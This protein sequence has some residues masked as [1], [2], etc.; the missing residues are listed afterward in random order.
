MRYLIAGSRPVLSPKRSGTK[1][2]VSRP[3]MLSKTLIFV[4]FDSKDI[5][6]ESEALYSARIR[7]AFSESPV[8]IDV[9]NQARVHCWYKTRFGYSINPYTSAANAIATFPTTS[10]AVG[11][12]LGHP[13]LKLCAPYGLCDLLGAVVRP[14]KAQITS[15]IYQDKVRRWINLWPELAICNWV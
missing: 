15:E 11:V 5:S 7:A 14:N 10:V 12:Q 3:A 9:K 13:V 6:E 4:Y 2:S 8:K 1:G